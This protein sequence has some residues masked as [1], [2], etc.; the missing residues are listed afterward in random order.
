[1]G[2]PLRYYFLWHRADSLHLDNLWARKV[3]DL[4]EL[5]LGWRVKEAVVGVSSYPWSIPW[6]H[7]VV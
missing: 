5:E 6:F 1:M 4:R 2:Y 3:N 7:L